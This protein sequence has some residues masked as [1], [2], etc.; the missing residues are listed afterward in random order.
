M[1]IFNKMILICCSILL[2]FSLFPMIVQAHSI[3]EVVNEA[4][5]FINAGQ[6][7]PIKQNNLKETSDMIY[8][9]ALSLGTLIAVAVGS[10]LGIKFMMAGAEG[11]AEI[12][13]KL[14]P[15]VVGCIILFGAFGIWKLVLTLAAS[16]Q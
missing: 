7:I 11:K 10:F 2:L 13:E 6:N 15:F 1:K 14:I 3:D 8:N 9:I 5:S 12:K 4:D 16:I